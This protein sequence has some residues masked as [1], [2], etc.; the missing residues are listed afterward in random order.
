MGTIILWMGLSYV[1]IMVGAAVA[2]AIH[3]FIRAIVGDN[4]SSNH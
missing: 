1:L 3:G 2:G 4:N